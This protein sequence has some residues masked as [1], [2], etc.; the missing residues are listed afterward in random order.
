[1]DGMDAGRS[2]A[3]PDPVWV[4]WSRRRIAATPRQAACQ[5]SGEAVVLHLDS[6]LYYG[7]DEVGAVIWERICRRGETPSTQ[8]L[9]D[10]ILDAFE[11][12]SSTCEQDLLELLGSLER[13]G[14]IEVRDEPAA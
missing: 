14:L 1:M 10:A 13:A 5:L 12:D 8:D 7:L 9:R 6:G 11:V 3:G 2:P 4:D